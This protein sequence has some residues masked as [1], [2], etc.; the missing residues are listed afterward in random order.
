MLDHLH[1]DHDIELLPPGGQVLGPFGLVIDFKALR[2]GVC[3]RRLNA[4]FRRV[5]A[6]DICAQSRHGFA[7]Q[8]A[9]TADISDLQTL[10]RSNGKRVA[11]KMGANLVADETQPHG[12]ER[13]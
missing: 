4:V 2:G 5:E 8:A 10:E 7:Q 3:P 12:V 9:A 11:V 1:G 13:V 6:C